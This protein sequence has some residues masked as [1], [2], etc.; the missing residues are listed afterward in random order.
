MLYIKKDRNYQLILFKKRIQRISKASL[1]AVQEKKRMKV[2]IVGGGAAGIS[3]A[4]NIRRNDD[5]AEIIVITMEKHITIHPAIPYVLS[6]DVEHFEDIVMHQ[7][8]DYLEKN[9]KVITNSE[10]FEIKSNENKLK[11]R[12]KISISV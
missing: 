5:D 10:V 8:E 12:I 2:V 4:S 11:Y 7:P 3:T 6:G 9:I 1:W